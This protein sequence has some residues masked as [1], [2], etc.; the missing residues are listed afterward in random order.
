[1][2]QNYPTELQLDKD[3]EAP[4]FGFEFTAIKWYYFFKMYDS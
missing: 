2:D 4:L 3:I 1:M